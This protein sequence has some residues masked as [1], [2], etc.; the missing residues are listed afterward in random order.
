MRGTWSSVSGSVT[1]FGPDSGSP[2]T[3]PGW[4]PPQRSTRGGEVDRVPR[5]DVPQI[6]Q[7]G[8]MQVGLVGQT[9][10]LGERELVPHGVDLCT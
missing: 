3:R 6:G 5:G 1:G 8:A 4:R 9:G 7:P 10:L 2:S